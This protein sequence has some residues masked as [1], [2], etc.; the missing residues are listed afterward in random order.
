MDHGMFLIQGNRC[1]LAADKDADPH[2]AT[3]AK[4]NATIL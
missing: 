1:S 2:D 3:A 4:E